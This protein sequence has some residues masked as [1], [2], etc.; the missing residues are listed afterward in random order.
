M[1]NLPPGVTQADIDAAIGPIEYSDEETQIY[2]AYLDS[3]N[4]DTQPE[5]K[6]TYL[7]DYWAGVAADE[8]YERWRDQQYERGEW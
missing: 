3:L 1:S 2:Q 4:K 5:D 6:N 7:N 8:A